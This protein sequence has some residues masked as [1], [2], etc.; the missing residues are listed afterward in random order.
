VVDADAWS[1]RGIQEENIKG[2][3]GMNVRRGGSRRC[4]GN[5]G[6]IIGESLGA[7]FMWKEDKRITLESTCSSDRD[8][9]LRI[10]FPHFKT[11]KQATPRG[12]GFVIFQIKPETNE[13]ETN[14]PL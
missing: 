5:G 1:I 10:I 4:N 13:L 11:C 12:N 14:E 7:L 3:T 2:L 6:V 8:T 9:T